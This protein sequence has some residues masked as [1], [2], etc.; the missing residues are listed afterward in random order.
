MGKGQ[1]C[2]VTNKEAAFAYQRTIATHRAKG[3]GVSTTGR[4]DK[5][6]E[7]PDNHGL[8]HTELKQRWP[9]QSGEKVVQRKICRKPNRPH[10]N[11]VIPGSGWLP[12][13]FKDT[14]DAAS[15]HS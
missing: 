7:R 10:L 6:A 1:N 15:F 2:G 13:H 11:V 14:L 12:V 5:D 8:L 3:G 9:K 4:P